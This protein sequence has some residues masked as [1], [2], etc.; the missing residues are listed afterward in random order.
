MNERLRMLIF[1]ALL[2]IMVWQNERWRQI[3]KQWEQV[4][5]RWKEV[6]EACM[7]QK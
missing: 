6:A 7:A 5:R 3:N 2:V 1:T 4:A